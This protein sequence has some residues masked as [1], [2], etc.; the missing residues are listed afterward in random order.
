MN[1]IHNWIPQIPSISVTAQR[2]RIQNW[3]RK[4]TE[5]LPRSPMALNPYVRSFWAF[6]PSAKGCLF[7]WQP[8]PAEHFIHGG[9]P[10][11]RGMSALDLE[12]FQLA[13]FP[14]GKVI[15]DRQLQ[16]TRVH[17]AWNLC[18]PIDGC[19]ATI[20]FFGYR[21]FGNDRLLRYLLAGPF[22]FLCPKDLSIAVQF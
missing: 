5:W 6:D 11:D 15:S 1:E 21:K 19:H 10:S 12:D 16:R 4:T 9:R 14:Q 13:R 8:W 7:V 22:R 2:S 3:I 18:I 17:F 20:R